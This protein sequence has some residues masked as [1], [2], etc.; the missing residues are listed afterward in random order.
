MQRWLIYDELLE[1]NPEEVP[2]LAISFTQ[3][4]PLLLLVP[5]SGT[6]QRGLTTSYFLLVGHRISLFSLFVPS[7]NLKLWLSV[8]RLSR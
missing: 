1:D 7:R 4:F 3:R 5:H 6:L 2:G 8:P